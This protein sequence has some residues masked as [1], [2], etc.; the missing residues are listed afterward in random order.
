MKNIKT[1]KELN[2]DE[3]SSKT[4]F[5]KFKADL[6]SKREI[7]KKQYKDKIQKL[8]SEW[9]GKKFD[10]NV[11]DDMDELDNAKHLFWFKIVE[12]GWEPKEYEKLKIKYN[13]YKLDADPYNEIIIL[14]ENMYDEVVKELN[15]DPL[16]FE[17]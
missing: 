11:E 3:N 17:L 6:I 1:F 10:E 13:F 15:L 12:A 14:T 16:I 9:L 7:I 5:E 8:F 2:E 4:E